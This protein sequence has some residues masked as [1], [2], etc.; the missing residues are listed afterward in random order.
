MWYLVIELQVKCASVFL[1]FKTI[2]SDFFLVTQNKF[3]TFFS[4]MFHSVNLRKFQNLEAASVGHSFW[5]RWTIFNHHILGE[6]F[7]AR[8]PVSAHKFFFILIRKFSGDFYAN[9]RLT[10]QGSS[11][12]L[13]IIMEFPIY[14]LCLRF[15]PWIIIHN[16]YMINP[17]KSVFLNV[18]RQKNYGKVVSYV[19]LIWNV[20]SIWKNDCMKES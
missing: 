15:R 20:L 5:L 19:S 1:L 14:Y 3:V 18:Q 2:I 10:T 17:W 16:I 6:A 7:E 8:K 11:R 13:S 4:V 9:P 12:N